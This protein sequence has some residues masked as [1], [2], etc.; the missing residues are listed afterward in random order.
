MKLENDFDIISK[1]S[2]AEFGYD[3]KKQSLRNLKI[4]AVI[5]GALSIVDIYQNDF[6]FVSK[7]FDYGVCNVTMNIL[8]ALLYGKLLKQNKQLMA[9]FDLLYLIHKLESLNVQTSLDMLKE[10]EVTK[11]SYKL[12][13]NENKLPIIKQNKYILI[14]TYSE[15]T[16]DS[17]VSLLQEHNLGS[18]KYILSVGE[19]QKKLTK[20]LAYN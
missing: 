1:I 15:F 9:G 20:K 6:N 3:I 16:T 14:P 17:K 5:Y 12:V 13:I 11:T 2:E 10:A 8:D 19:P 18:R 4:T 7:L